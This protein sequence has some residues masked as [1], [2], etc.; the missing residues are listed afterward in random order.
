MTL[1]DRN[2]PAIAVFFMATFAMAMIFGSAVLQNGSPVRPEYYGQVVYEIPAMLWVSA[3]AGT[4]IGAI[5]GCV[6]KWPWVGAVA[7]L[8]QGGLFLFFGVQ[9]EAAG[10]M[11]TLLVAM[12][13]PS[14]AL[15]GVAAA[16][17]AYGKR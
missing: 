13:L 17:M 1:F 12:A 15:C 5:A 2:A 14:S 7:A 4:S 9:A 16:V 6:F 10:D 3:Q 8:L 11:G